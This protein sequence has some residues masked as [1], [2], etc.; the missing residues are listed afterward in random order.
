MATPT[1]I[2]VPR[3][4]NHLNLICNCC[5]VKYYFCYVLVF[6]FVLVTL[7]YRMSDL[8]RC[9]LRQIVSTREL[10]ASV[11]AFIATYSGVTERTIGI[12]KSQLVRINYVW[13]YSWSLVSRI[14]ISL[15][16]LALNPVYLWDIPTLFR[17]LEL[18]YHQYADS[19][20]CSPNISY[21]ADNYGEFV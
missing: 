8:V 1:F 19:P 16:V 15:D 4:L 21:G 5:R 2:L 10:I 14:S 11:S 7:R 9:R 6:V 18:Y 17:R 3:S 13:N 20:Y 12:I